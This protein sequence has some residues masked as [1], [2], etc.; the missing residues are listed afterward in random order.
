VNGVRFSGWLDQGER[1]ALRARARANGCSE[2]LVLRMAL[3]QALGLP[4]PEWA[5]PLVG[6]LEPVSR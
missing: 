3:R 2:N 6:E 5:L 1:E 4:V